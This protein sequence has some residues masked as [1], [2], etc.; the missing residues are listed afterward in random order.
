MDIWN[1]FSVAK[2]ISNISISGSIKT[3]AFFPLISYYGPNPT[4]GVWKGT[5]A[6]QAIHTAVLVNKKAA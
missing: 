4:T 5:S 3:K 6:V 2:K 1:A